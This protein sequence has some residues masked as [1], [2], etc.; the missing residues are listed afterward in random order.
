MTFWS[1]KTRQQETLSSVWQ[2][3]FQILSEI[4]GVSA[5]SEDPET[6]LLSETFLFKSSLDEGAKELLWGVQPN[7]GF[8]RIS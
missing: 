2:L 8:Y 5:R 1:V 4:P 7:L 3:H 6:L